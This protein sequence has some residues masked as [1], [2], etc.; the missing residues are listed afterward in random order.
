MRLLDL[1]GKRFGRLV[2]IEPGERKPGQRCRYWVCACDCGATKAVRSDHLR[3]GLIVS[4]GCRQLAVGGLSETPTYIIWNGMIARCCRPQSRGYQWYGARG[5]DVCERWLTF[6]NFLHDMGDRPPGMTLER[7]DNDRGY[8]P[9]NCYWAT[10]QQQ[11]NNT[12]RNRYLII[13]GER[14]SLAT[15]AAESGIPY[16]RL[17]KRLDLGWSIEEALS[18]PLRSTPEWWQARIAQAG[19]A[20]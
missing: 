18:A 2:V 19:D 10:R 20:S 4:C 7:R 6:E 14:K 15:A 1:T 12:R 17:K 11:A 8:A 3:N 5:I 13:A 16:S 9:D